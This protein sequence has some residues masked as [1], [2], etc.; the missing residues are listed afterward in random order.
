VTTQGFGNIPW[1]YGDLFEDMPQLGFQTQLANMFPR[2]GQGS[3]QGRYWANRFGQ[4]QN[5][6]LGAVGQQLQS[7]QPPTLRFQDFLSQ[8]PFTSRF[9]ALPP[10]ARGQVN[11]RFNPR[12]RWLTF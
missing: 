11:Q 12:T 5:E 8:Y 10:E 7:G 6:Y 2:S 3:N 9:S 1:P 4:V